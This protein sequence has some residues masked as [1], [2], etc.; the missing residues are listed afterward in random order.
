LDALRILIVDATRSGQ[1]LVGILG[2][3][4]CFVSCVA[5]AEYLPT[6]WDAIFACTQ[7]DLLRLRAL[8]PDTP[9]IVVFNKGE[10]V[11]GAAATIARPVKASRVFEALAHVR[12]LAD[13]QPSPAVVEPCALRG[14]IL[15]AEDNLVN[16][17]LA[18]KLVTNLGLTADVASDGNAALRAAAGKDYDLILMDCQMPGLDGYE[19]TRHLR[20]NASTASVPIVAMTANAMKGDRDRCLAAGMTDYISKP[21]SAERLRALLSQYLPAAESL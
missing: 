19:C 21:V 20:A 3:N 4:A 10:T 1:T 13:N 6:R 15:I 5:D 17:M 12:L 2:E 7:A 8:F 16:Q 11:E 18:V 9:L 14:H